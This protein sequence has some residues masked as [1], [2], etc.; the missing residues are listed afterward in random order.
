[1]NRQP[2]KTHAIAIAHTTD[3]TRDRARHIAIATVYAAS[4]LA[5]LAIALVS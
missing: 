5:A 2:R 3:I 4:A 1:M